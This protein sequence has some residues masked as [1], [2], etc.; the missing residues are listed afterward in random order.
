M[1]KKKS[2][3]NFTG[4]LQRFFFCVL[5]CSGLITDLKTDKKINKN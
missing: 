4:K 5:S 2:L 1:S 3:G